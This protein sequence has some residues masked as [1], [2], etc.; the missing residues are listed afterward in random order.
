MSVIAM[1]V[2]YSYN[3]VNQRAVRLPFLRFSK[4]N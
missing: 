2:K 4:N 1:I 3:I